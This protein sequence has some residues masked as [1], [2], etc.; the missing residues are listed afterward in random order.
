MELFFFQKLV[1]AQN[2][3]LTPNINYIWLNDDTFQ[4]GYSSM[5]MLSLGDSL[6][7][8]IK[9]N[10][11]KIPPENS[12][13]YVSSYIF[14]IVGI[15][16]E[17]G[18]LFREGKA[19]ITVSFVAQDKEK[20]EEVAK[21]F[22]PKLN[23]KIINNQVEFYYEIG[24]RKVKIIFSL[25]CIPEDIRNEISSL[26]LAL[27]GTGLTLEYYYK[28]FGHYPSTGEILSNGSD[29]LVYIKKK[30]F[31]RANKLKGET[32][33]RLGFVVEVNYD[34]KDLSLF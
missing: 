29:A 4:E 12:L 30:Y 21:E 17:K 33:D 5:V 10:G 26:N 28:T 6:R 11:N 23:G 20:A 2:Q 15:E 8:I 14:K 13:I 9:K 24:G 3:K 19:T 31:F 16:K 1:M 22:E 27:A 34:E 7:D 18:G 25:S 32:Q